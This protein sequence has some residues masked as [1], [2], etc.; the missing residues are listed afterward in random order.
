[1]QPLWQEGSCG[2]RLLEK[3][4]D[5]KPKP[6]PNSQSSN[7]KG[8]DGKDKKFQSG[9]RGRGRGGRQAKGRGRGNKFQTVDGEEEY[10]EQND[11]CEDEDEPEGDEGGENPGPKGEDPSGSVNQVNQ[12]TMCIRGKPKPSAVAASIS[13]TE[14]VVCESHRVDEIN[15]VEK[16][17]SIGVGDLKRRWLLDSGATATCHIIS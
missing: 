6:K 4:P 13:S 11:D 1:M 3:H 16:F 2:K 5:K 10:D 14:R 8:N 12:M 7:P 15:L 9:G 17:Q